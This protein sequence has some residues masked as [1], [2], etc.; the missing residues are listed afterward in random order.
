MTMKEKIVRLR[1]ERGLSQER[2]AEEI[3]VSRQSVAKWETGQSLPDLP[4]LIALADL[5]QISLDRLAKENEY[6]ERRFETQWRSPDDENCINFLLKAK[7]KTYAAKG[8][9]TEPS[10]PGSHDLRYEEDDFLYIDTY[11]GSD[12]FAGEEA[13]WNR[14]TPIWA[15]NYVGRVFSDSFSGDFLKEVLLNVPHGEPFRGPQLYIKGD[16]TYHNSITGS[17][18]WFEGKEEIFCRAEKVYECLYHGGKIL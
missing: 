16:Y 12:R 11:L 17:F 15:M 6:D 14:G 9:E 2:L 10:R 18:N 7:K 5:F 13:L 3:G 4:K 1:N 8:A